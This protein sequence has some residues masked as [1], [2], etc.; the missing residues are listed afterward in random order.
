VRDRATIS[1][2]PTI[3]EIAEGRYMAFDG[4][5][6][7]AAFAGL[8]ISVKTVLFYAYSA[9]NTEQFVD[10][11]GGTHYVQVFAGNVTATG[12]DTPTFYVDGAA[13]A[14]FSTG[15][16]HMVAVTTATAFTCPTLQWGTDNVNFGAVRIRKAM[17]FDRVLSA[18][19][20]LSIYN[21]SVF[22]Y[23]LA[24][25]FR[26]TMSEVNPQD[27]SH[28]G[29]GH[30]GTGV[31]IVASTDILQG[32]TGQCT[33]YNGTDERTDF[34]D[35]GTIRT[36]EMVCKPMSVTEELL[37]LDTG[38]D[39]MISGGVITYA[40][41]TAAATYVNGVATTAALA[42]WQHLVFV[43]T[44]ALDANNFEVATDGANFGNIQVQEITCYSSALTQ[45][46]ANDLKKMRGL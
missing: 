30:N 33:E 26:S 39:I 8:N 36:I 29:G 3:G 43:L 34:G 10:F 44:A 42:T 37:L 14:G 40:G 46:Q 24:E 25:T 7:K 15:A 27:V 2:L 28:A 19:E 12:W 41:T 16:W 20:I 38:I 11:D 21:G 35:L 18:A 13:G 22:A 32:I 31:G 23:E 6:D 9:S 1:S 4:T 17:T 5:D 45:I